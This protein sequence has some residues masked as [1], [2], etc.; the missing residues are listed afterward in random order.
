MTRLMKTSPRHTDCVKG[1]DGAVHPKSQLLVGFYV[2]SDN[3]DAYF[4]VDGGDDWCIP[5][6]GGTFVTFDGLRPHRTVISA[7]HVD[8]LGPFDMKSGKCVW[9]LLQDE[10]GGET[11]GGKSN[12]DAHHRRTLEQQQLQGEASNSSSV[13]TEITG[14]V[15]IFG[16]EG[17]IDPNTNAT[18]LTLFVKYDLK[19]CEE[20]GSCYSVHF[21]ELANFC[22]TVNIGEDGGEEGDRVVVLDNVVDPQV[23]SDNEKDGIQSD[24]YINVGKN[25]EHF[26]GL[27]MVVEDREGHVR[28]CAIFTQ[29][30]AD[31][32]ENELS[33]TTT[34][35]STTAEET[36]KNNTD[37]TPSGASSIEGGAFVS[38]TL[39]SLV[40][41]LL[42]IALTA[43]TIT[44]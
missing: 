3:P 12:F 20:E 14:T 29:L 42:V 2:I 34:A 15:T 21:K 7:G 5:I 32:I 38:A 11:K 41:S 37:N 35:D 36:V 4:E 22:D 40:S 17:G 23:D 9:M 43:A 33:N 16:H 26:F 28:G 6:V 44:H 8:L 25:V 39:V 30:T 18:N 1:E 27:P 10:D 13:V 19:G 24:T 31:E